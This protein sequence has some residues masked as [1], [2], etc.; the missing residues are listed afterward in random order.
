[1]QKYRA[2]KYG[3]RSRVKFLVVIDFRARSF[4]S[5]HLFMEFNYNSVKHWVFLENN[6]ES[7]WRTQP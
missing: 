1:M 2:G 3:N 7:L 5:I 6:K 4:K